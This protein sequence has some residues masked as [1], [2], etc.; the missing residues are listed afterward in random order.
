MDWVRSHLGDMRNA[1]GARNPRAGARTIEGQ[2]VI[3]AFHVVTFDAAH[4]QRQLPMG[5]GILERGGMAVL[6]AVKN[7]VFAED[8]DRF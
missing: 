8:R 7:D 5:T 1:L 3:A 6:L 4:G 2:A